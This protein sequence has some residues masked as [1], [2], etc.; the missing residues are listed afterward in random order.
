MSTNRRVEDDPTLT[1]QKGLLSHPGTLMTAGMAILFTAY[2]FNVGGLQTWADG[3]FNNFNQS[4]QSH[5]DSVVQMTM[6]LAPF[7]AGAIVLL[8]VYWILRSM[9]RGV[10]KM[11][12]ESRLSSR[13]SQTMSDFCDLAAQIPTSRK[14]ATQTYRFL[15]PYYHDDVRANLNDRLRED[16][17]MTDVQVRDAMANLLHRCDRKKN[18]EARP[19]GIQ[20]IR[21]LL[22]YVEKAPA[23]FLTHSAVR[24]LRGEKNAPLVVRSAAVGETKMVKP[25]H[26]RSGFMKAAKQP[27][28]A[29]ETQSPAVQAPVEPR[30]PV[31]RPVSP[32]PGIANGRQARPGVSFDKH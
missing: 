18:L 21:D 16:L 17:H 10:R 4:T 24:R 32:D 20:T 6:T 31:S 12:K 8:L 1:R 28:P 22:A 19:E 7:A 25:L 14:V 2:I 27:V 26:K 13:E 11:Q 29:A 23:H 30:D 3:L 9:G 15:M 5:N